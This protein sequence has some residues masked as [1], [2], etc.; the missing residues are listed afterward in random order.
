MVC[1]YVGFSVTG[2]K[3]NT[4]QLIR[5]YLL[6]RLAPDSL[7][8]SVSIG[9]LAIRISCSKV[10]NMYYSVLEC[11]NALFEFYYI[12]GDI[13][14]VVHKQMCR[15]VFDVVLVRLLWDLRNTV[16]LLLLEDV[17]ATA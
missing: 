3:E 10:K 8:L 17:S 1:R 16:G 14:S 2:P 4:V 7:M 9:S 12:L 15:A 5:L 13:T 6:P 11:C